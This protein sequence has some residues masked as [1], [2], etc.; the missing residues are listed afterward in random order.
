MPGIAWVPVT[1]SKFLV[2]VPYPVPGESEWDRRRREY[3]DEEWVKCLSGLGWERT[4]P[5]E[6]LEASEENRLAF[7]R[8][9]T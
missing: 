1:E 5:E 2:L 6:M 3:F 4:K 9:V 7:L 8:L